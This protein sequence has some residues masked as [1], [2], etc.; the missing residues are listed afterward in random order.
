MEAG[1]PSSGFRRRRAAGWA[2]VILML[3]LGAARADVLAISDD[4]TVTVNS[5]PAL[6]TSPDLHPQPLLPP[7]WNETSH[8]ASHA[9]VATVDIR[10]AIATSAAHH[11]LSPVLVSAVAWRESAF[12]A[13]ALSSKGARGIMQLMP[14]TARRYCTEACLPSDNVE[15]GTAYLSELLAHYDGDIV[16]ALSAYDAGPGAVDRFRGMPPY[17]ETKDYVDAILARMASN[18]LA[19]PN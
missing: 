7:A 9:R 6:Y 19:G 12:D 16:K 5:G 3:S 17:R 4:G 13:A 18:A 14:D 10:T 1:L 15:A 2:G 11:A 8:R